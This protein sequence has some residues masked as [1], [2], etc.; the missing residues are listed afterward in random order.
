M[1]KNIQPK[2]YGLDH[3][4]TFAILFVF[5]FHYFILSDEQPEWLSRFVKFGWTGVD[6]FFVLS[7]FLISSQLFA[8]IKQEQNIL[9]KQFF[10]KRFFRTIPAFLVTVGLYFCFPF[11]VKKKG[12]LHCGNFSLLL[13]ILD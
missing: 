7:G 3:L 1:G 2:L 12:C 8:Q 9:F 13:K 6:L 11:F 4:R 10:L 5:L